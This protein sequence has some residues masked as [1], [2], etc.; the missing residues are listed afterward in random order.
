MCFIYFLPILFTS[1]KAMM[2][3]GDDP[4]ITEFNPKAPLCIM[5]LLFAMFYF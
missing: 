3:F 2:N 1:S 5:T 4:M